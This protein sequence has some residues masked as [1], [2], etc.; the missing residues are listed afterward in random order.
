MATSRNPPALAFRADPAAPE[1][2]YL[3]L[4]AALSAAIR[5]G[6]IAIGARLPS[7]RIYAGQLGVSRTTVIAAYQELKAAGLARGHVGRGTV[8][9]ADDPDRAPRGAIAW[10]QLASRLARSARPVLLPVKPGLISLGNGWLHP[11]LVPRAALAAC[12]VK[13]I[14]DPDVMAKSTLML[15]LPALREALV[16][17]LRASGVKA[18]PGE[19]LVTGGAQQG[20]HVIARAFL[21]PGD[22][23]V[24]ESPTFP[25]AF[26]AFRAAGAE[27]TGV[28]MDH[29]GMD[30]EALE[31]ALVRLRPKL[32]YLIPSF[33]CPTGRLMG[34]ARRRRILELCARFRTPIV[35]SHVYGDIAF[36]AAPP[37]LK[38]LDTQGV[39]ILQGSASK[40]ISGGL[41]LGWLVAPASAMDLLAPSKASLDLST[42]ALAQSVLATFLGNGDYSRH[43]PK[44]RAA[45][46]DRCDALL[47]ALAT[48]CPELG[49]V[50]PRG[51]L[52]LW[53]HLP[54]PVQ[55]YE[56][57][58]A[59]A[60]AG[61]SIRGGDAFL[62]DGGL[63]SHIRLC[64]GAS[65]WEEIAPGAQRL[66]KALRLVLQRHK[67]PRARTS[68]FAS[69]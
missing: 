38:S 33:Q 2:I 57:E 24:C 22:A 52:Y 41:R 1:P 39:V 44:M 43:L 50:A 9:I 5:A 62:P 8:V 63:S 26:G 31:D 58:S 6:R 34:I 18:T 23:V 17:T 61:V 42:P 32:V 28:A 66:G 49:L 36:G 3:Q 19:I 51:G 60:G 12:A 67:D 55:A 65:A 35:E 45:L 20:L 11:S 56:L 29:E 16:D 53:A 27:V 64:Y 7:E 21:S 68:A 47:A 14:E 15:G 54:K 13:A 59:A 37:S 25:G 69:V 30:P 10:P 4:T 48:H 40:A 46:R